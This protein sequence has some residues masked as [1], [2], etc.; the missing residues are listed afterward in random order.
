[1]DDCPYCDGTGE[2]DWL[3]G[4]RCY[5][6]NGTGISKDDDPCPQCRSDEA[7]SGRCLEDPSG[8]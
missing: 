5:E 1:M 7:C 8:H 4:A 3:S 6:C 2:R